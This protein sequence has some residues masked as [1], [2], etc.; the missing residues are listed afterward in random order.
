VLDSLMVMFS[1]SPFRCRACSRRFYVADS[2][3]AGQEPDDDEHVDE[4]ADA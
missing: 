1:R 4:A 3:E 2:A